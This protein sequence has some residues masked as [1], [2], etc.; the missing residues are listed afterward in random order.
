LRDVAAA[1]CTEDAIVTLAT[2]MD[3]SL[4]IPQRS[5]VHCLDLDCAVTRAGAE[6]DAVDRR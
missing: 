3:L 2:A 4:Y 1:A 6:A 5:T